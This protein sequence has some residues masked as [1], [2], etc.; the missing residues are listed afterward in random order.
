MAY[1]IPI[2]FLIYNRPS[3]TSKVFER[4]RAIQP[5]QLYVACDGPRLNH[6]DDH[7]LVNQSR[8]IIESID[9]NCSLHKLYRETNFGCRLA[10]SG[11]LKWFFSSV[12]KGIVLEDDVLPSSEFFSSIQ[13]YLDAYQYDMNISSVCG[14]NE[15]S[16]T[17][18]TANI[19]VLTDKFWCWGWASWSNRF[20][21]YNFDDAYK[22]SFMTLY[23]TESAFERAYTNSMLTAMQLGTVNTWD[24]PL[25][26]F[27]RS[28]G[29][30]SMLLPF[31]CI[32]NLG[33]GSGTHTVSGHSDVAVHQSPSNMICL[34]NTPCYDK[35]HTLKIFKARYSHSRLILLRF[36]IINYFLPISLLVNRLRLFINRFF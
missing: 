29:M 24:Y 33:F 7:L 11:A 10:V 2:L 5:T 27:F 6:Y 8:S 31:N 4:I 35:T 25:D 28:C 3:L 12:E 20:A 1:S 26:L 32:I 15:L 34:Q 9:W 13:F 14:R 17:Q 22:D 30:K 19:P 16:L 21:R 23:K 18:M 36:V